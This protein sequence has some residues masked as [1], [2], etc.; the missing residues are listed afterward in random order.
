MKKLKPVTWAGLAVLVLV[1]PSGSARAAVQGTP[2]M[3][4]AVIRSTVDKYC[5]T[6]HNERLKT[7]GLV[8]QGIDV[9]RLPA[10]GEIW[11]KVIKKLRSGAM[12]PAT[13]P[14]PQG[15]VLANI[16]DHLETSLD[17]YSAKSPDPGRPV[18]HRLNRAEYTNAVR[19]LLGVVIDGKA[20]LPA[21]D[22]SYG[23][24]NVADVLSVTSGLLERYLLVAKKVS[25]LAMGD[26][27]IRASVDSYKLPPSL[28]QEDR[29]ADDLPFGSR[30]GLAVRQ[31]FPVDGDYDLRLKLQRNSINLAYA[32][33]GM[34]EEN[35]IDVHID[36]ERVQRFVVPPKKG[37]LAPGV[38]TGVNA[39]EMEQKLKVRIPVK[40]GVRTVAVSFPRRHW[41]VE[42]VGVGRL[43]AASDAFNSGTET[44]GQFGKIEMGIDTLEIT[45][46][47]NGQAP[48][49]T[50]SRK[51]ILSCR[52]ASAAA[53]TPCAHRIVTALARRAYRRE[54][55]VDDIETLMAF[56]RDGRRD[57][58]FE[59]GIQTA[60]E[61][62]LVSPYFLLRKER[63]QPDGK[64]GPYRIT[65]T[66]LAS[67]LSFF[68]W[69]SIPDDQ[70]LTLAAAGRLSRPA[71][72]EA[73]VRRMLKDDRSQAFFSN[74][75]GQWLYLRNL[76]SHRPDTKLFPLFDENLRDAFKRETELFLQS[77]FR[78]DRSALELLT[79]DYTFVNERL[80][81]HYGI[82]GVYGSHFRRVALTDGVRSGL[83]G[84]G[85]ILTVTSYADRTSPVVRG[86]WLLENIL[87]TPPPPPPANVPPFPENKG[88]EAPKSV[89]ARME[90]HRRNPVCASCHAR[91]DPLGFA[92]ENFD[93]VGR[94]RT[95]DDGTPV[96]ASGVL[97]DGSKFTGPKEFRVALL[98]QK[99]QLVEATTE[100]LL[101]YALGRGVQFYD[102]PAVRQIVRQA[103]ASDYRWSALIVNLVK[104][105]PFQMRRAES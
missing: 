92:L 83:L 94:Y 29:M 64:S 45:G 103:A 78:E 56:Y 86:K 25:R 30:G 43:P 63:D 31:V 100:K 90:Q 2:A 74:F 69:S 77:Q 49:A 8:L 85:S 24:D 27:T 59:T 97:P 88:G 58:T 38:G 95:V 19:D 104:S 87:G 47:F 68:L 7:G 67:R 102:M 96:D 21:D 91:I 48:A 66:E 62:V 57:A 55:T 81:R 13:A 39:N 22:A 6:C 34:D 93:G 72:L 80:A 98:K 18:V 70:L 23:F 10:S 16:A 41:Y 51:R 37:A 40:A 5:V 36:G 65:D 32:I 71:E 28:L 101:T 44:D 4:A 82:P 20:L 61:R 14:K 12:P 1:L 9:E 54:P 15:T 26:P 52:P 50:P 89:R 105:V 17:A 35:V 3:D 11:E 73:Q 75:F 46:P 53:E 33:R 42:G 79:A 99:E 84:Q 60:I 76:D